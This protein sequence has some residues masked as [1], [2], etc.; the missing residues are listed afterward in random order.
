MAEATR[1]TG[2]AGI[3]VGVSPTAKLAVPRLWLIVTVLELAEPLVN[4]SEL[5]P[6]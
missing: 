3:V 2:E 6:P 5:E 4:V 1:Q